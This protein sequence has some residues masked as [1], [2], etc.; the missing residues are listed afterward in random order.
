MSDEDKDKVSEEDSDKEEQSETEKDSSS[1]QRPKRRRFG[2]RYLIIG[3]VVIVGGVFAFREVHQ[4]LIYVY[5]YDAR[6]AGDMV[7]VS[8]RV[9][10]WVTALPVT[11]GQLINSDQMLV[12]IDDRESKLL[13]KQL[14][15]Q[16]DAIKAQRDRLITQRSLVDVQT[17]SRV[18]TQLAAVNAAAATV[19]ALKP[20]LENAR[21]NFAREKA[22]FKKKVISRRQFDQTRTT[23]QQVDGEYRT[24]VAEL[25]EAR[26][27]LREARADQQQLAVLD[28]EIE[29][30]V[31]E[32]NELYA[33]IDRQ[34]LDRADRTIGSPVNGV[35]DRVFVEEG[36]YVTPGQR[37]LLV[38]DPKRVWI[39]A[40]VKETDI[41]KVKIGQVADVTVDAFPDKK[42]SGKVIAIGNAATSEFALLPTPNPSGNFTKITQR[43][44]VRVAID[45]EQNLLRPGMMVEVFIDVR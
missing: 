21:S 32:E 38:H 4:R 39:D 19:D 7:T 8:S 16:R 37:L 14:E 45:Q 10:G 29:I 9:A 20:Q 27:R 35:V 40:N 31:H 33:Q 26:N 36:E 17:K 41:R 13:V 24:S 6:I 2:I 12:K 1:A 15:A 42:F 28:S 23:M 44:R 11:E 18:N 30:L 34:R 5:E 22:L 43:L 3:L 25:E